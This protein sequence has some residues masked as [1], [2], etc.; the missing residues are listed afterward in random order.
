M[1]CGDS[2]AKGSLCGCRATTATNSPR[3]ATSW[4]CA[5]HQGVLALAAPLPRLPDDA[6]RTQELSRAWRQLDR[7]LDRFTDNALTAA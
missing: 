4:P 1:T 2:N 3:S 6:R 5:V 7:R